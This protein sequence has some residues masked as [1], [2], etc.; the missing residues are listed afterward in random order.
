MAA[1][2]FSEADRHHGVHADGA[3]ISLPAA[4]IC[5]TLAVLAG[6]TG[7]GRPVGAS[8]DTTSDCAGGLQCFEQMCVPRCLH[9]VDCGDG[10]TCESGNCRRVEAG[11]G[12]PCESELACGPGFTCRLNDELAS[13]KGTCRPNGLTGVPGGECTSDAGCRSGVCALGHC[14]EMCIEETE[15]LRGWTCAALPDVTPDG[16]DDNGDFKACLPETGTLTYEIPIDPATPTPEL[17]IAV[18]S[19][20]VSAEFV[21]TVADPFQTIGA[22]YLESPS[23]GVLYRNLGLL[24]PIY[25]KPVRHQPG[26]GISVVKYPST[27]DQEFEAG[28]YTMHIGVRRDDGRPLNFDRRLRVM[29]KL[30]L[31]VALDLHF[32]IADLSEHPCAEQLGPLGTVGQAAGAAAEM[33]EFQAFVGEI[34]D[35]LAPALA[36]GDT[37][38]EELVGYEDLH[39]LVADRA[40]DLFSLNQH[41]DGVA[42]YLV[43]SISPAGVQIVVGGT[44]GSPLAATRSS[45]VAISMDALCYRDWNMLARQTAHAIARHLGLPRNVEPDGSDDNIDDSPDTADNLMHYN[46]FSGTVLSPGQRQMLRLSPVV[47]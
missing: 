31:G 16:L 27:P 37:T 6:C 44:P 30:D 1:P 5:I 25:D 33:P 17:K 18:P 22:T 12:T 15:C 9:H 2:V 32:Y 29:L 34:R 39:G 46:E 10:H 3:G 11:D 42:I 47:R 36:S 23:G 35:I 21:M 8:C 28:A 45:G 43:R 7:G 13:V 4:M 20:A 24:E 14:L 38:Y 41:H 40:G 26:P 19:N